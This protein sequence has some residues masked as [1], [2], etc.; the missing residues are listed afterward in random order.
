MGERYDAS[1]IGGLLIA[2]LNTGIFAIFVYFYFISIF[3]TIETL[4]ESCFV[5]RFVLR[6]SA[7]EAIFFVSALRANQPRFAVGA[8]SGSSIGSSL[9]VCLCGFFLYSNKT[10]LFHKKKTVVSTIALGSCIYIGAGSRKQQSIVLQPAVNET[11]GF[12]CVDLKFVLV[13]QKSRFDD[14]A[15]Y[16]WHLL[17]FRLYFV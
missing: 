12:C 3:D 11:I 13:F 9:I 1:I 6:I 17:L 8:V 4:H 2:W 14:N 16:Y 15:R 7:P 5:V 10:F